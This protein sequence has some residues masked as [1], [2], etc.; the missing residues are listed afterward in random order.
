MNEK[1][2]HRFTESSMEA[3]AK[4]RKQELKNEGERREKW[5]ENNRITQ[6]ITS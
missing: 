5:H 6:L 3:M 2:I 4:T 1:G